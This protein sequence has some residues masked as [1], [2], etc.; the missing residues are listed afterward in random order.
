MSAQA[1]AREQAAHIPRWVRARLQSRNISIDGPAEFRTAA[2]LLIDIAGFTA[3]T[4]RAAGDGAESLTYFIND[5]FAVLVDVIEAQGGDI[6]AF[7]GDAILAV[8]SDADAAAATE[9][10][11]RCALALR[12]AMTDW[13]NGEGINARTAIEIGEVFFCKLGGWRDK[14]HYIAVGDP[15]Y[16]IGEAYQKAGIGDIALCANAVGLLSGG[17]E[18]EPT[19]YGA[20]LLQINAPNAVELPVRASQR[21]EDRAVRNPD[22]PSDWVGEFRTL[23][24]A[25]IGLPDFQFEQNFLT[26][27]QSFV[28]DVQQ[29]AERLEGTVHQVLMDDKGLTLT[30]VFGLAPFAHED[31]SFRAVEACL[32]LRRQL[33]ANSIST[34]VGISTGRLFCSN[35]GGLHQKTFGIFGQAINVA[36]HFAE[37]AQGDIVC[38]A[39][40]A[41]AVGRRVAFTLLPHFQVKGTGASILAFNP[42]AVAEDLHVPKRRTIID[43]TSETALLSSCLNGL[44]TG[45]GKLIQILG[46]AGIGKSHLLEEFVGLAQ[47]GGHAVLIA[48]G[49]AIEKSTPY[50]V[51]RTVL[52]QILR[53][54]SAADGPRVRRELSETLLGNESLS[55]WLPL[56]EEVIPLGFSQSVFTEQ[57]VGSAR[58]SAIEELVIF[59]LRRSQ[60]RILVM[61]DVHWF[62]GPSTELLG[63]VARRLSEFLIVVTQ[64]TETAAMPKELPAVELTPSLQ[65][66]LDGLSRDH[67]RLLVERRLRSDEI[68]S[69][70][71]QY[72]YGHASGNPFFSEEL[73]L[74]LRDTGKIQVLRGVCSLNEQ[75]FADSSISLS[76]SVERAIVS[77]IDL[78]SPDDQFLLKAASAVGD[79]FS[80]DL[81][82][83]IVPELPAAA[84]A[85]CVQR[86]MDHDFLQLDREARP[87]SFVFR[88]SITMEVAYNLLSFAQRKTLHQRIAAFIE[89][90]HANELQ[91]NYARLARHLEL[92]GEPLRAIAYLELAAQQSRNN[93]ANREAIR[94]AQKMFNLT[95]RDTLQIDQ[96]R[97]AA[98]EVI[99]GDAYH[100]LSDY[101]NSSEHYGRAMRLLGH[102]LPDS[103]FAKLAAL[104]QNL[105]TQLSLWLFPRT[106][107]YRSEQESA[108][109]ERVSHIY[110]YLSE[111]YFFQN[112]SLAVLNGTLAS[113]NLAE[114]CGAARETIRGYSAL[115]LGMGMSGLVGIACAYGSRAT[116]LA[117]QHGTLP[118]I[119]RVQLV[120]GVL[121]YGLGKWESAERGAE[122]ARQ[123]YERLG[124]RKRAHNC[125]TMAIFISLLR[126]E[127]SRADSRLKELLTKIS[128]DSP[129]QVRAWSL[130]AGV[131]ID[132]SLARGDAARLEELRSLV[133]NNLIRTDQLLC[134]GTCALGY[135]ELADADRA[136][137]LAES[138]LAILRE[139]GVVWGGYVYGAAGIADVLLNH[140][141]RGSGAVPAS[142]QNQARQACRELS[143]LARSSP[144][145][146][147]YDFLMKGRLLLLT[148]QRSKALDCWKRAAT[149]AEL[150]QM[151]RERARAL[152]EIGKALN[153]TASDRT[154]HLEQAAAIFERLG[155]VRELAEL[156]EVQ[157]PSSHPPRSVA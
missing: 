138:G 45:G 104:M 73:A 107:A 146:R 105:A 1:T 49:T 32:R 74:A 113:L 47:A 72:V 58:A 53:F 41:Q 115:A 152:Y 61:E 69:E 141:Q 143:R 15:F 85:K 33:E 87:L 57:I 29:I 106:R 39:T 154:G 134:V 155:A 71:V 150:L 31:D 148:G 78:L 91:P 21:I 8:W 46:E 80:S 26:K 110:E 128:D 103:K 3:K 19:S 56:I 36:A 64:R 24:V 11:A 136:L 127:I 65:V 22:S 124:D 89:S 130:S 81:L 139:C 108:D 10:A 147:P 48:N 119:A 38:D 135:S 125:E 131:L 132:H 25:R 66:R 14:W 92:G 86:L 96:S 18:V 67:V 112:D 149:A 156:R 82:D 84:K 94:Y 40:T 55:N 17:C 100:E 7:A 83:W 126:G 117:D 116:Q 44:G 98:W 12:Q 88:H 122:Q 68:P 37:A 54:E 151:P 133:G 140:W 120:L 59:L 137:E 43:R 79:A 9:Q 70:L 60:F 27:L 16:R 77:R 6:V 63:A 2:V 20:R 76:T 90:H 51:W 23:T 114:Q 4:D 93:S 99:L 111:Q 144:L 142:I 129:P 42:T 97:R 35:Y 145:C 34:S 13:R 95:Q 102:R 121:D 157:G 101:S 5:C 62:D 75:N 118:E 109:V 153:E 50:F 123:L 30:L 52:R 28:L